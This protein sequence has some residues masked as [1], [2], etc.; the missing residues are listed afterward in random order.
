MKTPD[1]GKVIP[2]PR[3]MSGE[4]VRGLI[5]WLDGL[6]LREVEELRTAHESL[7]AVREELGRECELI[8]CLTRQRDDR[9]TENAKLREELERWKQAHAAVQKEKGDAALLYL[10]QSSKLRE[11]LERVKALHQHMLDGPLTTAQKEC[12]QLR[13]QVRVALD[14]LKWIDDNAHPHDKIRA[15]ARACIAKLGGSEPKERGV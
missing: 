5:E 12:H 1:E 7:R 6:D 4:E 14:A 9:T 8:V 15:I 10:N 11:E 2:I 13:E 3:W